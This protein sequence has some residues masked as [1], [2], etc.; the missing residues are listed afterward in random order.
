MSMHMF[1]P[2][3]A[4]E[5]GINAAVIYQNIAFWC[6]RNEANG[7]NMHEGR[8]WTFNSVKAYGILFP[9]LTSDQIRRSLEKL[10]DV[11]LLG[12]GFFHEDQRVRTKWFCVLRQAHLAS[13]P[14]SFGI[15]AKCTKD[16]DVNTDINTDNKHD[17]REGLF[18][19]IETPEAKKPTDSFEEFWEAYPKK[20]GKPAAE[21]A[22]QKAIK[23]GHD[24]AAIITGAKRYALW[25]SSG[26]PKDFRPTVKFPQ[27]WLNDERWNDADLPELPNPDAPRRSTLLGPGWG[28][29]VR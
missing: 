5:V 12:V 4:Q 1:D 23:K 17:V 28:E 7:E 27:G 26:G 29:V 15:S 24:A 18:D 16:T 10:V 14:S 25:L 11:G 20:A 9:Y 2:D 6:E 22:Y 3:I 19:A 21:K 13:V 8:S